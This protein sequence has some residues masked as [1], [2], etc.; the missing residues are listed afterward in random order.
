MNKTAK[1]IGLGLAFPATFA[2][3]MIAG[4]DVPV[5]SASS[6]EPEILEVEVPVEKIVEVPVEVEKIVEVEV[7]VMPE[8]CQE[9]LVEGHRAINTLD[10]LFSWTAELIEAAATDDMAAVMDLNYVLETRVNSGMDDGVLVNFDAAAETCSEE[11]G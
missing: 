3:G 5:E 4:A 1:R 8:A 7:P 11:A 10:F 6:P 9:A 2:V